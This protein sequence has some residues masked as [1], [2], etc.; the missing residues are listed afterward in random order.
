M[1]NTPPFCPLGKKYQ[2]AALPDI[3]GET[4]TTRDDITLPWFILGIKIRDE[5]GTTTGNIDIL[6]EEAP[7]NIIFWATDFLYVNIV[8]I[9]DYT[10]SQLEFTDILGATFEFEQNIDT[11]SLII[12]KNGVEI[13]N[14]TGYCLEGTL[15]PIIGMQYYAFG[16]E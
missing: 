9:S 6:F 4:F 12:R 1:N 13:Y 15:Y 7:V 5:E 14:E 16:G 3:S 8:T 2:F 10:Q 11:E